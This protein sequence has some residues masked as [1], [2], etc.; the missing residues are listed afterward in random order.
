MRPQEEMFRDPQPDL[1]EEEGGLILNTTDEILTRLRAGEDG[2]AEFKELHFGERGVL[3]PNTEDFAAEMV[4]FANGWGGTIFLGVDDEGSVVGVPAEQRERVEQWVLNIATLGCDP[5]IRPEIRR[6][7]LPLPESGEATVVTVVIPEGLFVH[8]TSG[9]RYYARLGSIRRR[10]VGSELAHLFHERARG[11]GFDEQRVSSGTVGDLDRNRLEAFFGRTPP[12]PWP[13]LLRKSK[14]TIRDRRGVDR[15]SVAGLLA[16]AREPTDHLMSAYIEA[17]CYG[18]TRLT[19][20]DLVH[21]ERL[22]GPVADQIDAAVAFVM[23]H[24]RRGRLAGFADAYDIDVVDEAIVN[25]V[26]HRDYFVSGSTIRLF[27]YSDRLEV[28]SPGKLPNGL[29]IQ[30]MPYRMF[31]RNQLLVSFLSKMR[32]KRTGRVFL[33]GRGEGVRRILDGG[34]AHSGRRPVYEMVGE[35][36]RLTVWGRGMR[37]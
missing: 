30:E 20:D 5:P 17:A 11:Y 23:L 32:S 22:A 7:A 12:I 6:K 8:R 37:G 36:M 4:A 21:A 14:V 19:S 1:F 15:P 27:L 16:F 34:E 3:S 28:Y 10:L 31:T 26:A 24:M 13:E 9:G 2:R 35:E 33:E 18:G 25:A 29:A